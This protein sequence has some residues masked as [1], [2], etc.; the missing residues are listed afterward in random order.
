MLDRYFVEKPI[1]ALSVRLTGP[2]AHHLAQVARAKVGQ[3]VLLFDGRGGEHL[4]EV[5]TLGRGEVE[6]AV[7]SHEPDDR[8]PAI[9]LRLAVALPKGDR[10]RLLVEKCVELG[11]TQ[12]IPLR[13]ARGVAECSVHVLERLHRQ[14]I[15]A[16]KQC[17]RNRLLVIRPAMDFA[18]LAAT[19]ARGPRLLAH[20]SRSTP[21]DIDL[22]WPIFEPAKPITAAI[23]PEG[24]FTDSEVA[25]AVTAGWHVVSLGPRILRVE[26]AAAVVAVRCLA[27]AS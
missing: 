25:T 4:V 21:E 7:L 14:A 5:R 11:V 26:T 12:L 18:S 22:P 6:L 3:H 10:Q 9:E 2:Q 15:E 1:A 27:G 8:M 19:E 13:A 17:G 16:C 20:L 24:G 23:G